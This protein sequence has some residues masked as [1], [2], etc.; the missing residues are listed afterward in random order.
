MNV[1]WLQSLDEYNMLATLDRTSGNV[2]KYSRQHGH[3]DEYTTN[4]MSGSFS[5]ANGQFM[6]LYNSHG[7]LFFW[8]MGKEYLLDNSTIVDVYGKGVKRH[9]SIIKN[10]NVIAACDYYPS[11]DAISGDTTSFIYDED[12][13]YGLFVSNVY[14]SI[15]RKKIFLGM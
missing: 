5:D 7:Q 4:A 10:G 9:L 3:F 8:L 1:L 12:F 2:H 14:K 6:A 15:D 13:D 11:P